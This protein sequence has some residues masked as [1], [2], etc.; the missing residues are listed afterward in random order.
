MIRNSF[1]FFFDVGYNL[2]AADF[3]SPSLN[4]N[5]VFLRK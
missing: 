1:V 5:L 2:I 3:H 4:R